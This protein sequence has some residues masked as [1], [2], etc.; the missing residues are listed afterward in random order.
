MIIVLFIISA[1]CRDNTLI[2][3]SIA[4]QPI[5]AVCIGYNIVEEFQVKLHTNFDA[6]ER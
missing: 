1:S 6:N 4:V 5:A 3:F 2:V